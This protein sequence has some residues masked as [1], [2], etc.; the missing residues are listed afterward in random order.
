MQAI[1]E[2][3]EGFKPCPF[4]GKIE[5]LKID[6]EAQFYELQGKHGSAALS[7]EC[8]KCRAQMWEHSHSVHNYGT[9]V[10]MLRKR[11]NTRKGA[12]DGETT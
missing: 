5:T 6:A 4:C 9:R 1:N 7:I 10:R 2:V 11:W 8:T 3:L 12:P